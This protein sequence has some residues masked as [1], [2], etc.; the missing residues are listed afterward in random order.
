LALSFLSTGPAPGA[1]RIGVIDIGSNSIRLVVYERA[2][3]AAMPIFNEKILC[4]LGRGLERTGRLHPDGVKLAIE[5]LARF[6]RIAAAM[7]LDRLDL[8]ATAA[9]RDAV[10]G[11]AFVTEV[12]RITGRRVQILEGSE[13]ARL[14]AH[15]VLSGIPDADGAM[16]DLGGGSLE[17]VGLDR[18]SIVGPQVTLPLGPLRLMEMEEGRSGLTRHI[19]RHLE[20]LPLLSR[21]EGR[22]FYPVGG[23]WRAVAKAH[24]EQTN[25]PLH[26]IHHYVV[27]AGAMRDFAEL[28]SRQSRSSLERASGFPRKRADTLPHAALLLER[29]IRRAR[30]VRIVFSAYGLRDGH[31]FELLPDGERARDPLLSACEDHAKRIGRFEPTQALS[32]WTAPLF[33]DEGEARSRLRQAAC[34]LSDLAWADHPDYRADHAFLRVLRSPYPGIDHPGRAFLA[35]TL[36]ARYTGRIDDPI[37]RPALELMDEGMVRQARCLGAALRLAHSLTGGA[38]D[39]LASAS[40]EVANGRLRLVLHGPAA[41]LAGDVVNRRVDAVADAMGLKGD[42]WVVR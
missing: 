18:G 31:L 37:T 16:G 21:V 15:G 25:H 26:V 20:A 19:D 12:E 17:V 29:L 42:V 5:N 39:L 40:L 2:S 13:E 28:V 9:A 10:D 3:R 7:Q 22:N 35:L 24:M 33:P 23:S 14:S 36:Y 30:P 32:L 1:G 38:V 6:A 11:P 41:D 34:L 8:L 4:G 27:E